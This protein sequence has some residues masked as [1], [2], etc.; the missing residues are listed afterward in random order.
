MPTAWQSSELNDPH[1]RSDKA[2]KVRGMFAAI[3]SSY[4]LNNRLHSLWQDQAW[5]RFAVRAAA[6]KP[7]DVVLD[8]ACGTGDLTRALAKG[9]AARVTG[10]D[11][12]REMLDIADRKRV[13]A[14]RGPLHDRINYLEGDAQALPFPDASFDILSIAFGIRNVQDPAIALAEFRRVLKPGGRLIVLEFDRPTLPLVGALSDFYTRKIMPITAT[15]IS[16][17]R[18]GAYKY[19]PASVATFMNRSV[20]GA[21]ILRSGFQDLKQTG[22]SLGVCVCHR[23]VAV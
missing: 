1:A 16:G 17:D 4:D 8:V 12:T 5:R 13:A 18:S 10:L 20:L 19:L 7:T 9:G 11:F 23:A 14:A 6:V 21:L 3:A 2:G 22:L 15:L